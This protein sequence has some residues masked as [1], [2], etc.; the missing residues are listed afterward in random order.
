MN[1]AQVK[2]KIFRNSNAKVV[3]SS[4][5]G[6]RSYTYNGRKITDFHYGIDYATYGKNLA[7]Y[8][9]TEGKV[10]K[11]GKDN[12]SGNYIYIEYPSLGIM[13]F[14]CH[15]KSVP[16]V[17]KGAKVSAN[18]KV[19]YVG[20]TGQSTGEHLHLGIKYI[21]SSSWINPA[22]VSITEVEYGYVANTYL[23][24]KTKLTTD[25]LNMRKAP[26]TTGAKILTIPK[27]KA[28]EIIKENYKT[29]NGFKWD[30]IKYN[31]KTG[32]VANAYLKARTKTTT[33]NVNMRSGAGTNYNII[34]TLKKGANVTIAT[35]NSK[36][37]NGHNW[38]K[39]KL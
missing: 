37:A 36:S 18:T 5:Y 13:S 9:I 29:A 16:L 31:N 3:I 2:S 34:K 26:G 33:T 1:L 39:I 23:V 4:T 38:D 6:K 21:G 24:D 12:T 32:Y 22:N 14:Y 27:G 17:K 11:I 7:L 35:E 20:T 15:L 10:Y 30:K 28:V 19:G 8:P 25:N